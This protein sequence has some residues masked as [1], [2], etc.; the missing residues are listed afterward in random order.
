M[1]NLEASNGIYKG[2]VSSG[3]VGSCVEWITLLDNNERLPLK[4]FFVFLKEFHLS[5]HKSFFLI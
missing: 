5:V 1:L 3:E 2:L 4:I